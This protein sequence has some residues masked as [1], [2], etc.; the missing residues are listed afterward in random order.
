[1]SKFFKFRI[2]AGASRSKA[3]HIVESR[4]EVEAVLPKDRPVI[5]CRYAGRVKHA[6]YLVAWNGRTFCWQLRSNNE[7][8]TQ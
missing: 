1:M 3:S 4:A 2:Y 8:S 5:V 7:R 6:T